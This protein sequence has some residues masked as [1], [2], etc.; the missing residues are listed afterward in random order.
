MPFPH[1]RPGP[2]HRTRYAMG[3]LFSRIV[4]PRHTSFLRGSQRLPSACLICRT[5]PSLPL[6]EDCVNT[7]AQP[8][9]RCP[10]CAL[11]LEST[12]P[13]HGCPNCEQHPPVLHGCVAA[14]D[15]AY[16]WD[17]CI[18]D[19][20]F[21]GRPAMARVFAELMLHA[22]GIAPALERADG[23]IPVPLASERLRSRGFNQAHELARR[24]CPTRH[25]PHLL[26]RSRATPRQAL[27][28]TAERQTNMVGAMQVHPLRAHRVRGRRFVLVDDILTTGATLNEA[29]RCLLR[30][31]AREVVGV[32]LARTPAVS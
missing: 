19:F 7:F 28:K 32:V 15:Y 8:R 10:T 24:L 1:H 23:V 27:L 13:A 30:A 21:G 11:P 26:W 18:A 20:K 25:D 9:T 14:L 31:G 16:P 4:A 2:L 12:G 3:Q 5:W 22:P 6:C 17:R 29:A